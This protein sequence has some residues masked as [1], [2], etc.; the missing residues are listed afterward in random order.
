MAPLSG[1]EAISPALEETQRQLL[2]PFR[3]SRWTRLALVSLLTGEMAGGGGSLNFNFPF[4]GGKSGR[5]SGWEWLRWAIGDRI[6]EFLP[7]II[8]GALVL[9]ALFVFFIYVSSVFRF[10]LFDSVLYDRSELRAGWRNYKQPGGSYFLWQIGFGLATLASFALIIIVPI[11]SPWGRAAVENPKAHIPL[12]VVG[13]VLM[14]L[15]VMA[16]MIVSGLISVFAR[17]FVVPF[18]ALE[19]LGAMAAWR[20]VFAELK[21]QKGACALYVLMKMVLA[22]GTGIAFAFIDMAVLIV[23]LLPILL[24]GLVVVLSGQ[25]AGLAWNPITISLAVIAGGA[26]AGGLLFVMAMISVPVAV[27]FQAYALYFLGS[28]YP[29]LGDLMRARSAGPPSPGTLPPAAA[30]LPA[31]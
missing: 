17:D 27:F 26:A 5:G 8:A 25:A 6:W 28:R 12:I 9:L 4:G 1:V 29:R 15:A 22:I 30:P 18:M 16:A 21:G 24:L 3:W 10:V 7:L 23:L 2:K 20:R 13:V 11:I 19:G 31:T 14:V